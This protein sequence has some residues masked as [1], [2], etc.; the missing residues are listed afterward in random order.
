MR[1]VIFGAGNALEEM[2]AS[3]VIYKHELVAV[4]DNSVQ[5]IGKKIRFQGNEIEI[6]SADYLT[7][8]VFDRIYISV[9]DKGSVFEI[10]MQLEK[11]GIGAD[12]MFCRNREDWKAVPIVRPWPQQ[13]IREG[14]IFYDV[15]QIVNKDIGTGIQRVV[16]NLFVN[17]RNLYMERIIPCRG[18]RDSCITARSYSC[19]LGSNSFDNVE[20]KL[21][22]SVS[23]KMLMA[24]ASW[25]PAARLLERGLGK[26][27]QIFT[28]VY[29]LMPLN[30]EW[31]PE[32]LSLQFEAWIT[33]VLRHAD[34]IVCISKTVA[35]KVEAYFK[36]K[37]I[38]RERPLKMYVCSHWGA[39]IPVLEGIAREEIQSFVKRTKT[40][41]MVGNVDIRKNQI[42]AL[43]AMQE[44]VECHPEVNLQLLILGRKAYKHEEVETYLTNNPTLENRVLWVIDASDEELQWAYKNT[45]ALLFLSKEEGFGL[46]LIEAAYHGLPILCSDIPVFHEVAGEGATYVGINGH[47]SVAKALLRWFEQENHPDSRIIPIHTWDQTAREIA[48]IL[49][50]RSEPYMI[51]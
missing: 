33:S 3:D 39:N 24:D 21:D 35:N 34:G 1:I 44:I 23:D 49:E 36:E 8:V 11:L 12:K 40:F 47:Q 5:K 10:T 29:D 13:S 14:R 32:S 18:L 7:S 6:I 50:R 9:Y 43:K 4:A 45:E 42:L 27:A 51:L 30:R 22:F 2:L 38:A 37:R 48:D 46:P 16:N 19:R 28:V 31:F 25:A 26:P 20:Y 17:L 41:L 15:T